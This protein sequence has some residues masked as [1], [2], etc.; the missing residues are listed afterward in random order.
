MSFPPCTETTTVILEI[1][2][3]YSLWERFD[4]L[5]IKPLISKALIRY[6]GLKFKI[7]R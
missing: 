7:K 4:R 3:K 2:L 1:G 5:K 6:I